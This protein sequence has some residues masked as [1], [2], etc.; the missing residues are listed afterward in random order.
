MSKSVLTNPDLTVESKLR[1]RVEQLFTIR[2]EFLKVDADRTALKKAGSKC[3]KAFEREF[4]YSLK[5]AR[6][7]AKLKTGQV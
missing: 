6:A 2:R 1:Q 5:P 7:K 4:R 3:Y